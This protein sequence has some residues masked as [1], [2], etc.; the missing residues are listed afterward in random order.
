MS[1]RFPQAIA[2]VGDLQ[3]IS[4]ADEIFIHVDHDQPMWSED[5]DRAVRFEIAFEK[6]FGAIPNITLGLTGIDSSQDKNLRFSLSSTDV[7]QAGFTIEFTTWDDTRI[8][9]ASASW[10]AVGRVRKTASSKRR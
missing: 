3:I 6:P 8:A 9:R 1:D 4:S 2:V 5:G 7:S 10:Q